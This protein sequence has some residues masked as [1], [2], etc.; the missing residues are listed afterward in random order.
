MQ[1]L[2]ELARLVQGTF[3][4]WRRHL[5][6]LLTWLA[7][8]W[9]VREL[10]FHLGVLFGS[11]RVAALVCFAFGMV[12]WVVC[13]IGMLFTVTRRPRSFE[14]VQRRTGAP[15]V[16]PRRW[17]DVMVEAVVPFLALY[18][19]WG[20]TEDQVQRAF[21]ANLAWWGLDAANFS[22][23][24]AQWQLYIVVTVV[25]WALQAALAF[26]LRNRRKGVLVSILLTFL[27]GVAILTAFLGLDTIWK[28]SLAWLRDRQLWGW[29]SDA[30]DAFVTALPRWQLPVGLELPEAVDRLGHLVWS[31]LLPG[32]LGGVLLPLLWLALTA[33]TV[34]WQDFT[35]GLPGGR[36]VGVLDGA[37]DRVKRIGT[38]H[39][40]TP[41]G[42]AGRVVAGQLESLLPVVEAFRLVVRA[43]LPLLGSYLF[44]AAVGRGLSGWLDDAIIW[45][46][47]PNTTAVTIRYTA[48]TE[49]VAELL[50]WPLLVCLYATT[51][52]R[53]LQ[54]SL[55]TDQPSE[56]KPIP[57]RSTA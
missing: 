28:R 31:G 33:L 56:E 3:A 21:T 42:V 53:V 19:V 17:R 38:G 23:S 35:G 24:F 15:P 14:D 29:G 47:G 16:P 20:L 8:G 22:I 12:F 30:W 57:T 52:D 32:L 43:G 1:T 41:L 11:N 37:A 26:A 44:L 2:D 18:A 46:V 55:L 50:A 13:I 25:A 39:Q 48:V 7:M 40:R 10:S 9:A 51:F 36:V 49:L 5:P 54:V 27:R 34:G 45:M 4:L 6:A